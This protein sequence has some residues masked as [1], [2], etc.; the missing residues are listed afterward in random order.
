MYNEDEKK[1]I[2]YEHAHQSTDPIRSRS[3]TDRKYDIDYVANRL[4]DL[5]GQDEFVYVRQENV[6]PLPQILNGMLDILADQK[7]STTR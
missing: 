5:L 7:K 4:I 6:L 1:E 2:Y 3:G